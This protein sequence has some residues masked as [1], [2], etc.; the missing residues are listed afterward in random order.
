MQQD[1]NIQVYM[2]RIQ[3]SSMKIIQPRVSI[4]TKLE[5]ASKKCMGK[6]SMV[7]NK[8]QNYTRSNTSHVNNETL[9]VGNTHKHHC[10][11][12]NQVKTIY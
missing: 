2:Q 1:R 8:Q 6:F 11:M 7:Y 12:S 5:Q 9:Q 4:E 10:K 3:Y